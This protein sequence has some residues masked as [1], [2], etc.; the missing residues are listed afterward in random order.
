MMAAAAVPILLTDNKIR[1][2]CK[3]RI[4]VHQSVF[5]LEMLQKCFVAI[6]GL[7]CLLE[8]NRA[9]YILLSWSE[10][11][12]EWQLIAICAAVCKFFAIPIT[13]SFLFQ[14][15]QLTCN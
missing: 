9:V 12:T 15:L 7:I 5:G 6:Y 8:M 11:G 1:S 14:N 3:E 2:E 4:S 13:C 10:N